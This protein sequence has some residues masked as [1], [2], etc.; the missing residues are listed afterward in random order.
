MN[1]DQ[2]LIVY[3][4][5]PFCA[6]KC[7]FCDWVQEIPVND[8]RLTSAS[9]RRQAYIH[10]LQKQIAY[11]GPR[12]MDEG[13]RPRI[14]YWG[15]GTGNIL[16]VDETRVLM[17][18]L[19]QYLH[20]DDIDEATIEGSPENFTLPQ[21]RVL[22]EVGFNR[23]SIGVQS[24]DDDRLRHLGRTHSTVQAMR[25]VFDAREAGFADISIDLITGF[26]DETLDELENSMQKVLALPIDHASVYPYRPASRTVMHRMLRHGSTG[27]LDLEE[28]LTAYA[29]CAQ[30]FID[31]GYPEYSFG[32]FGYPISRSDMAYFKLE[33]DWIG[34]GSGASSLFGKRCYGTTRGML[35]QFIA[36]PTVFDTDVAASDPT[37]TG[38]AFYQA[39]STPEG[40]VA[41][42]WRERTGVE[43]DEILKQ[44]PVEEILRY[45]AGAAVLRYDADGVRLPRECIADA[46]INLLFLNAPQ[47][48]QSR[49]PADSNFGGF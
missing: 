20:L 46:Y 44:P 9:S 21:L 4:N 24:L 2:H 3:L 5:V 14:L 29:R 28:Q 16:T 10:A 30:L 27:K 32:H 22:R 36:N 26:P 43:L 33:M 18:T 31:A 40:A 41:R 34:F 35:D 45:M 6:S 1:C 42:L 39:L 8:L 19:H 11:Y 12:L 15:G 25:S 7:H 38:H 13:Y 17:D 48:S 49:I 47:E 37:V 23:V